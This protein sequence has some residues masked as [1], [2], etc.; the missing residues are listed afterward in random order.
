METSYQEGQRAYLNNVS[1]SSNP[2][3]ASNFRHQKW[4]A[5]WFNEQ[6]IANLDNITDK[7]NKG[8]IRGFGY[9]QG[10]ALEIR[11][12]YPGAKREEEF[13]QTT[14]EDAQ[15]IHD[16]LKKNINL[17]TYNELYLLMTKWKELQ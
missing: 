15:T 1:L 11:G 17:G 6:Q 5:G 12:S 16:F 13:E 14:K 10:N 3:P 7:S 2:Y 8:Y 4:A 9:C